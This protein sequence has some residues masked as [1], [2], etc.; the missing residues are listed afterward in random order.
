MIL[1]YVL[2]IYIYIYIYI[3]TY[4]HMLLHHNNTLYSLCLRVSVHSRESGGRGELGEPEGCTRRSDWAA[5]V[6][7]TGPLSHLG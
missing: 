5:D 1:R 3:H 7:G 4:I 6:G 2:L